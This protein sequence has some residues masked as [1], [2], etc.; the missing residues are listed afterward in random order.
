M[1]ATRVFQVYLVL[2]HIKGQV[3]G[4]PTLFSCFLYTVLLTSKK[5]RLQRERRHVRRQGVEMKSD[6]LFDK[7]RSNYWLRVAICNLASQSPCLA[8]VTQSHCNPH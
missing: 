6:E 2:M 4:T 5:W 7:L 1:I 8:G 3:A